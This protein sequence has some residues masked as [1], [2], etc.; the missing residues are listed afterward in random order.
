MNEATKTTTEETEPAI[1]LLRRYDE[2][3]R[4]M[5]QVERELGKAAADY[6]R[7]RGWWGFTRDH[8]RN[9]IKQG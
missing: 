4:E 5:M 9:H 2:L 8:L 3:R 1:I 7:A 6:G